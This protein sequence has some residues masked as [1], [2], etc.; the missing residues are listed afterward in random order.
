MDET[1]PM[2]DAITA[3]VAETM[4]TSTMNTS[5]EIVIESVSFYMSVATVVFLAL[6]VIFTLFIIFRL[7]ILFVTYIKT[8]E[9]GDFEDDCFVYSFLNGYPAKI[10]PALVYGIFPGAILVDIAGFMIM[11]AITGLFWPIP[12]ILL[13]F[14]GVAYLIRRPIARKQEFIAKLDGSYE[15]GS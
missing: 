8:G 15:E 4:N 7:A 2:A 3:C 11:A 1:G 6:A 14:I 12:T 10:L 5:T 9:I 13:P